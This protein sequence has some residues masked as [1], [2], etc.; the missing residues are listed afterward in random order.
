MS[1]YSDLNSRFHIEVVHPV[2]RGGNKDWFCDH[3]SKEALIELSKENPGFTV[4]V[5]RWARYRMVVKDGEVVKD[6][7]NLED[8]YLPQS[9]GDWRQ[10]CEEWAAMCRDTGG[11]FKGSKAMGDI[12]DYVVH[13][14][15]G[16]EKGEQ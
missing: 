14:A 1:E 16:S 8:F 3:I 15:K 13:T 10:M 11:H 6:N 4:S 7:P 5:S 9:T 12:V 2:D